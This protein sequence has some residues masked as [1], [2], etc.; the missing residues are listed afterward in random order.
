[1]SDLATAIMR[2]ADRDLAA[3]GAATDE[4]YARAV[5]LGFDIGADELELL[6]RTVG[7]Q[8]AQAVT[9]EE[10]ATIAGAAWAAGV[11]VGLNAAQI[12]AEREAKG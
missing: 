3:G 2:A 8:Y 1:M 5:C 7:L 12:G 4:E 11:L 10:P 6:A 9:D